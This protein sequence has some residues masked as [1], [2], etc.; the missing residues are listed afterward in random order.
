MLGV[1]LS[2][3][4]SL[5]IFWEAT[6]IPMFFLI[7]RW[8][9]K[10]RQTGALILAY[11]MGGSI[12]MLVS[13]IAVYQYV[14][15][16]VSLMSAMG[17]VSENMPKDQQIWAFLGFLIG[18]GVKMPIFPSSR[19]VTAG[20]RRGPEPRQ[21]PALRYFAEDGRLWPA[22][23]SDH[24]AP[25]RRGAA[26][27]TRIFGAVR[28]DIRGLACLAAKRSQSHGC[29]LLDQPHGYCLIGHLDIK[30]DRFYRCRI[31]DERAWANSRCVI[32]GSG[33]AL[34]THPYP[35]HTGLQLI[36]SGD[37]EI[38]IFYHHYVAGSDGNAWI[39]GG[40]RRIAHDSR[41]LPAMGRHYGVF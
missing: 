26:I 16:H 27:R 9:G 14:P 40:C 38:C 12:F 36:G 21:H 13:L 1:F 2:Q 39:G 23:R 41:G 18:F 15:E 19:L 7:D 35:Q 5:Y 24:P 11:T 34:R 25:C 33:P 32:H 10:R 30:P 31:A 17:D 8:G 20:S 28:H 4:W 22:S 6:L 29:L 3:D 37:A